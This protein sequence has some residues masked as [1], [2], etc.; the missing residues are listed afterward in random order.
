MAT[1]WILD[2]SVAVKLFATEPD[3][4]AVRLFLDK[5]TFDASLAAPALLRYEIGNALTKHGKVPADLDARLAKTLAVV[6]TI[7]PTDV[8]VHC[9]PLS[10]YDASYLALAVEQKAGLLTADDKLRKA[11]K[12]LG[13][14]VGP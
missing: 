9:G 4:E 3:S 13:I 8:A 11:A 7:D 14:E 12:K 1:K 2:A 5:A 10:Y 6:Q